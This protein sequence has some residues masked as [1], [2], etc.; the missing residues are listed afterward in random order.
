MLALPHDSKT[1]LLE[2]ADR[3]QMRHSRELAHRLDRNFD[4]SNLGVSK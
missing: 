4:L 1:G 3:L 2:C